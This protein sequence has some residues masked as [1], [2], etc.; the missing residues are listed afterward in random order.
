MLKKGK[1]EVEI[2]RLSAKSSEEIKHAKKLKHTSVKFQDEKLDTSREELTRKKGADK[3]EKNKETSKKKFDIASKQDFPIL[4]KSQT[5]SKTPTYSGRKDEVQAGEVISK[6][7]SKQ[8]SNQCKTA[9]S[10][11]CTHKPD[12]TQSLVKQKKQSEVA[13]QS[14]LKQAPSNPVKQKLK[15]V[16][17]KI[18][19]EGKIKQCRPKKSNIK[20]QPKKAQNKPKFTDEEILAAQIRED[21]LKELIKKAAKLHDHKNKDNM[22]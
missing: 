10:F 21:K 4:T 18:V 17:A 20:K 3:I 8:S 19:E 15:E 11:K 2:T 5:V 1:E 13:E 14:Q 6:P 7:V 9:K 22:I 16:E 12:T